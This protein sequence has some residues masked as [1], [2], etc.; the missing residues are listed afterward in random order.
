MSAT[1]KTLNTAELL[2]LILLELD[3]H[4]LLHCQRV[5]KF[6]QSSVE[7][8]QKLQRQLWLLPD[9]S[10]QAEER[11]EAQINPLIVRYHKSLGINS[12][13]ARYDKDTGKA[14]ALP[15]PYTLDNGYSGT[16]SLL[17]LAWRCKRDPRYNQQPLKSGSWQ[18]MMLIRAHL[19]VPCASDW[20]FHTVGTSW[21]SPGIFV[22]VDSDGLTWEHIET[23]DGGVTAS[24]EDRWWRGRSI[25]I[26]RDQVVTM[27]QLEVQML[28]PMYYL[29]KGNERERRSGTRS[30]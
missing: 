20:S 7:L 10:N 3:M 22:K 30:S 9:D 27:G 24:F 25:L 6:W 2:E 19:K 26:S 16:G 1:T 5:S 12:I 29:T 14:Y 4:T 8:S 17:Y 11:D 13:S 23:R 21:V 15:A 18:Q 28:G